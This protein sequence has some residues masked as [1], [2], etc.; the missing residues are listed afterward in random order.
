MAGSSPEAL[1]SLSLAPPLPPTSPVPATAARAPTAVMAATA[2]STTVPAVRAGTALTAAVARAVASTSPAARSKLPIRPLP[3]TRLPATTAVVAARVGLA[4]A[5]GAM[6]AMVA[7]A[8]STRAV[9]FTSGR[10]PLV[11]PMPPSPSTRPL[12]V[13]AP[14]RRALAV[15]TARPARFW[16]TRGRRHQRLIGGR[17]RLRRQHHH[18]QG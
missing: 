13:P 1:R 14:A 5:R 10:E 17:H 4:L 3:L 7:I 2:P 8:R 16:G 15:R 12:P 18:R 11:S 6:A 9:A